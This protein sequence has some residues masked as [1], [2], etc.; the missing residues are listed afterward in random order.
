MEETR[1]I[2]KYLDKEALILINSSV[3][4]LENPKSELG[5]LLH[6]PN[7]FEYLLGIVK[8][9]DFFP[10]LEEKAAQY[11]FKIITDHIFLD[12]NKRAGMA[13]VIWFLERN[14]A[15]LEP[16]SSDNIVNVSLSI[17]THKMDLK[18]LVNWIR[19]RIRFSESTTSQIV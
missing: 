9:D 19:K 3:I 17:A 12:G 16:L 5:G 10:T 2:V 1:P 13:A 8:D 7:S 18:K 6:C 11:C 14:T 15:Y 4:Q